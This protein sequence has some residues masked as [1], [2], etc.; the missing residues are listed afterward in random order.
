MTCPMCN[1]DTHIVDSRKNSDYVVR[2]RRCREC[3]YRFPTIEIDEDI[4][5]RR[6]KEQ[7]SADAIKLKEFKAALR[8]I[9][10]RLSDLE[11]KYD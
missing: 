2:H 11:G 1:G 6:K 4:H 8:E 10:G 5:Q 9:S 7:P 3:G